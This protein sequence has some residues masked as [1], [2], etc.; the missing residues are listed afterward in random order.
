M[1]PSTRSGD[2]CPIC[3]A[4]VAANPRYPNAVCPACL[5]KAVAPDGRALRFFNVSF[6]GGYYAEYVESGEEY[7]GHHCIIEGIACWADEAY[8][9]GI[10]AIPLL[11]PRM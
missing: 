11:A 5:E 6:S 7:S 9:G 8:L 1:Q 3:G 4:P 10:V 2:I